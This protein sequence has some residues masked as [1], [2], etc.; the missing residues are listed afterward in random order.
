MTANV[1]KFPQLKTKIACTS[2]AVEGGSAVLSCGH[3]PGPPGG[4][5]WLYN[6][7]P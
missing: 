5:G 6:G 3:G 1:A 4:R 2:R 7:A